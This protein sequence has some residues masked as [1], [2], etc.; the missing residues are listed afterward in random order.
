VPTIIVSAVGRAIFPLDEA[1][2]LG[3]GVYSA[4]LRQ[5]MVWLSALV[6]YEQTEAVFKRIGRQAIPASSVW[7]VVQSEG[8]R[9]Q[10]HVQQQQVAVGIDKLELPLNDHDCA[11]SMSLDGGM[12]NIRGEGWKE[13]KIGTVGEVI[14][15]PHHDHH[16]NA[17]MEL[18]QVVNTAYTAVLG[19]VKTFAPALWSLAVRHA[20]PTAKDSAVTADGAEWIWN[21]V[22]DYFPDS[23]QIVD[24]YHATQHL[25]E[26]AQ[27][28][29]PDQSEK[30][31][32]WLKQRKDDLFQGKLHCIT[33]PL[34][35]ADLSDHSRYFHTH[36]RRMQYQEFREDGWPIGSGTVESACK[37]FKARL[38][39]PGMRWS[40]LNAQRML[41]IRSAVLSNEFDSLWDPA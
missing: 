3:E 13:M 30:A 16:T 21:L 27:T 9:L 35:Q 28:L 1:W 34:D 25:A 33:T 17:P 11:K 31:E 37:Q 23:L 32:R 36:Q 20:V 18:P 8:E 38:T 7:R 41:I 10:H 2:E 5:R 40:R 19:D 14:L 12:V 29:F 24:W 15:K 4:Q 39:G 26:A 6:P 22:D